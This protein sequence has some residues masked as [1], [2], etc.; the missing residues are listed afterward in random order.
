MKSKLNKAFSEMTPEELFSVEGGCD[1]CV[2]DSFADSKCVCP[3][4]DPPVTAKYGIPPI[5]RYGVPVVS[6]YAVKPTPTDTDTSRR[7]E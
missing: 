5:L 7:S 4:C 1:C 3:C 6:L 2:S